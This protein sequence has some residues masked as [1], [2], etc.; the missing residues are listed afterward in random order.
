MSSEEDEPSSQMKKRGHP[1][2]SEESPPRK[3]RKGSDDD[4][5]GKHYAC[6]VSHVELKS[7]A[8][9]ESLFSRAVG[10]SLF[11]STVLPKC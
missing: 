4:L 9:S 5:D 2:T 1:S 8:G 6:E 7:R 10:E 3:V 11:Y